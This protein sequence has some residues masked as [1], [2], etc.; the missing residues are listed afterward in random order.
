MTEEKRL[1]PP[2]SAWW[3]PRAWSTH[4]GLSSPQVGKD[5]DLLEEAQRRNTKLI[6]GTEHLSLK[7][8]LRDL[9]LFS[10]KK[11]RLRGN[12]VVASSNYKQLL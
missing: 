9:G 10:L 3:D 4:S 8:R 5:I 1:A 12:L 7:E 11:T 2:S 6:R